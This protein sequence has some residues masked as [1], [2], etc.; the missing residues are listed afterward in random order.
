MLLWKYP[1]KWHEV[2]TVIYSFILIAKKK[3]KKEKKTSLKFCVLWNVSSRGCSYAYRAVYNDY[4]A[5]QT[6]K[7]MENLQMREI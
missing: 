7:K 3:K 4:Q 1:G 2:V 6:Q 5:V